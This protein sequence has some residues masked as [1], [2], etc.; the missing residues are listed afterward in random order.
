MNA[1]A[2]PDHAPPSDIA[3]EDGPLVE[4]VPVQA[5]RGPASP[6]MSSRLL[7]DCIHDGWRIPEPFWVDG[8]GR[9]INEADIRA[10]FDRERDWGAAALAG[11]VA[12]ALGLPGYLRVNV[13]RVLMDFGRF[14]G[15]T[16]PG[17]GHMHRYAINYPFSEL[18]SHEQKRLVLEGCYD[19]I[20]HEMEGIVRGKIIKIAFHTMDAVD[21]HGTLRPQ[22]SIISQAMGLGR[23]DG[24]LPV[25]AFDRL[26]PAILGEFTCD[27][28]LRDRLSLTLE[29]G[30]I[31]VAH[32]YP[33]LLPDGSI[34]VRTQVWFFFRYLRASFEDCFPDTRENPAYHM[35]WD[36]LTDTNLRSTQSE[37]LRSYLH[38]YRRV[39]APDEQRFQSA[40]QAYQ[41][42]AAFL[43]RDGGHLI[44]EYR[45]SPARPSSLGI[46]VRKDLVWEFDDRGRP[47]GP[48]P[49]GIAQIGD[50]IADALNIYLLDDRPE[51]MSARHYRFGDRPA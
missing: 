45:F 14:P 37:Q 48:K 1:R 30:R 27:R 42:V 4:M 12:G 24:A 22:A 13:A 32:N 33:Y 29:K 11:H 28:I 5:H 35:V 15:S 20:S 34:E 10:D 17:A 8:E 3:V 26:Y 50:L 9:P 31:P 2:L 21:A 43:Q 19:P 6:E 16:L 23:V 44:E 41:Q 46:E 39:D 40:R 47:V 18:L 51:A 36:M 25:G 49:D 7:F 38:L